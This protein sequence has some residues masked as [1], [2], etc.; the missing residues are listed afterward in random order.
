MN[1]YKTSLACMTAILDGYLFYVDDLPLAIREWWAWC[2]RSMAPHIKDAVEDVM[3][4]TDIR[5][6]KTP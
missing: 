6:Y 5:L 1:T 3:E 4:S 2:Y